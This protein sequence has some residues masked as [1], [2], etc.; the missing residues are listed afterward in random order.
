MPSEMH[1]QVGEFLP[2]RKEQEERLGRKLV[3]LAIEGSLAV[4]ITSESLH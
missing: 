1:G 2:Q 4:Y 3:E